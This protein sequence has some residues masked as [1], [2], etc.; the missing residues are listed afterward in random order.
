[1]TSGRVEK[2]MIDGRPFSMRQNMAM[3]I[4]GEVWDAAADR[5]VAEA[6]FLN[7]VIIE[8]ALMTRFFVGM[9]LSDE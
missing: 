8:C 2:I 3:D 4:P 6:G 5:S 7:P 9:D 1:M